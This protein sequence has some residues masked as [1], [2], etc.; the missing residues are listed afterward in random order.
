MKLFKGQDGVSPSNVDVV[1]ISF[2]WSESH[3]CL[4]PTGAPNP[5][6]TEHKIT[7]PEYVERTNTEFAK[8]GALGTT[9]VVSSGD[10]TTIVVPK[11]PIFA[12]SVLVHSTY[13]GVVILCSEQ[14][15]FGA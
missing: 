10:E 13:S 2:A 1:S 7:T 8:I 5:T 4:Q 9:I 3:Q 14:V 11:A 6:C 12:N 15:G